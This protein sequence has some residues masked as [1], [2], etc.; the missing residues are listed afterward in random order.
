MLRLGALIAGKQIHL[1]RRTAGRRSPRHFGLLR[2]CAGFL[3]CSRGLRLLAG[4]RRCTRRAGV[5][6]SALVWLR[7]ASRT[8]FGIGRST[9]RE[10]GSWHQLRLALRIVKKRLGRR[11]RRRN[12]FFAWC[13]VQ[14][15]Q[16]TEIKREKQRT[17]DHGKTSKTNHQ[18]SNEPE[19][20]ERRKQLEESGPGTLEAM[21]D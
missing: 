10:L 19:A 18:T 3:F 12:I 5:L 4:C 6:V 1:R 11:R 13:T 2:G 20:R 17:A 14:L 8:T 16:T 15:R 9:A 7:S 21:L